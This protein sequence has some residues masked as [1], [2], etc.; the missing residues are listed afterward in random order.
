[1]RDLLNR[2]LERLRLLKDGLAQI[3]LDKERNI[4]SMEDTEKARAIMQKAA[5]MSQDNLAA[6][7]SIIVTEAI[8]AVIGKPYV[9][10]CEFV[11]RRGT[12]EADL[13]LVKDFE[14][15]DILEGTGGGLADVVSFSLKVAYLLLSNKDKVLIIDEV[16]RHVNSPAQREAFAEVLTRLSKEFD[17]QMIINSTITE[18]IQETDRLFTLTQSKGITKVN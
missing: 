3:S 9:F 16:S 5:K 15:F 18:M 13:Y 2:N 11:E 17:I 7:L 12:T 1:M 4:Q 14:R 6:H 10:V 8:Q